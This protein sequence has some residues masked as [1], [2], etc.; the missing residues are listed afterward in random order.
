VTATE[1]RAHEP[2]RI[3]VLNERDLDN[4]LVGGAEVHVFEIFRRLVERGH[5]VR[6]LAASF[7]GAARSVT[8]EG[9]EVQR[10]GDRYRY[11]AQVPFAV[12]RAV[13]ARP[14]DVVVD[15]L[16][17]VPFVTPWVVNVPCCAIVHHLFGATA[18]RQVAFPFAAVTTLVEKLIPL[19]HRHTPMLAISESTR[20]DLIARGIAP[21]NVVVV[22]PGLD[23]SAYTPGGALG[24]RAPLIVWI[25]RLERYKRAD[26]LIDA[27]VAVR[28]AV[29]AAR[30]AIIGSGR[31]RDALEELVGRR[32]LADAVEFSGYIPEAEKIAYLQRAALLVNTS[33]KEGF[34][35]TTIEANAC[36]T[37]N[38]SSDVPGLR[39]SVR[40]GET[41]LLVPFGD[42]D[43]LA[44]AVVRLLTDE[45]LRARLVRNGLAWAARFSWE[46][47]ADAVED[48]IERA[49][50]L[51]RARRA[52][53]AAVRA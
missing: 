6:L 9:I 2:R 34:G 36:G 15:V 37:P 25:G 39:D 18:F 17:K 22:P 4:P 33:E 31:E 40:D 1:R 32:G 45:P 42:A 20:A 11:Y 16:N 48:L 12:R 29:P 23:V 3:V 44:R 27:F 7:R 26:V 13:A 19:A 43:A 53:G 35:L 47:A 52:D 49:I 38:V 46:R 30:L 10:L 41:G 50:A 24:D 28:R 14:T 8:M 51:H 5:T 21:D